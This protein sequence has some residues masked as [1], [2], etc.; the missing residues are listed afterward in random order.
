MEKRKRISTR[1]MSRE[2]WLEYRRTHGLGGSDMPVALNQSPFKSRYDLW[3]NKLGFE[4]EVVETPA[5]KRGTAM[6]EMIARL[7]A[8]QTG[9]KIRKRSEIIHHLTAPMF[10]DIDREIV[11]HDKG[12]GVLEIKCP[13]M[14]TFLRC[15]QEGLIPYYYIQLQHYLSCLGWSWGSL[16]VFNAELWELITLD[17]DRDEEVIS[18][19]EETACSFWQNVIDNVP[20]EDD[21]RSIVL[22]NAG[23]VIDLSDDFNQIAERVM[24]NESLLKDLNEKIKDLKAD[25]SQ[26][27]DVLTEAM[28]EASV[29]KNKKFYVSRGTRITKKLDTKR[30]AKDHPGIDLDSYLVMNTTAMPVKVKEERWAE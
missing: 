17:F 18:V 28:G 14:H 5:M 9:R 25:I 11:G 16:G 6:E 20:P 22:P 30:L 8:A 4:E 24:Q 27:K 12:P 1:G 2:E 13:G 21:A 23:V 26:D 29:A 19:I 15:K 3:C 7:Y 10:A